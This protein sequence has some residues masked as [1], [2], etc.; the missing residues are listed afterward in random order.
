[1]IFGLVVFLAMLPMDMAAAAK[2][3]YLDTG[4][5]W[6]AGHMEVINDFGGILSYGVGGA[7]VLRF[8]FSPTTVWVFL[9]LGCASEIGTVL[10]WKLTNRVA[11]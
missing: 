3:T 8:G 2:N 7:A 11:K 1:L 5:S 10:G 9:C 4:K 6:K